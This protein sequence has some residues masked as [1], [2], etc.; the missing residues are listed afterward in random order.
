MCDGVADCPDDASDES[1]ELCSGEC[2][3]GVVFQYHPLTL[4]VYLEA[5]VFSAI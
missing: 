4:T 5:A 2:S 3:S 1:E